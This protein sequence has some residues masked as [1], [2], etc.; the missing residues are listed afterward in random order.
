MKTHLPSFKKPS[1]TWF[2][3][4][5]C[6]AASL[7][8]GCAQALSPVYE[9]A[10]YS[11]AYPVP[12]PEPTPH[13]V[14]PTPHPAQLVASPGTQTLRSVGQMVQLSVKDRASGASL[15][16]YLFRGEYWVAGVPGQAYALTLSSGFKRRVL[17]TTSVDGVN[18]VS[19][20]TAGTLQRGY[21]LSPYA[22]YDIA[23]WRKSEHE[24]AAFNFAAPQ[25]SYAAQT[26]RPANV[27]VIGVA[28]F[29]EQFVPPAPP[30]S[31]PIA[32]PVPLPV[33]LPYP[34][35][36]RDKKTSTVQDAAKDT[37]KDT[38]QNTTMQDVAKSTAKNK[39]A[40]AAEA[41]ATPSA[42]PL[43][44]TARLPAGD[45]RA[46]A[47]RH[48]APSAAVMPGLGTQ[49]GQRESSY[50]PTVAFQR[51]S[52]TPAELISLRYDTV[53]H[54]VARG[55]LRWLGAYQP[56]MHAPAPF[57]QSGF[58]PDPPHLR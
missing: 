16:V 56:T 43:L 46:P 23:G 12:Q 57:P 48:A 52:Q 39:S 51:E 13:V 9:P 15:P 27:G 2:F 29:P 11:A 45:V 6:A 32:A 34:L 21:V 7:Q 3:L 30:V 44:D 37:S 33:P 26:G 17:A 58:V 36:R 49:H 5:L 18:V 50:A 31:A 42:R 22:R 14:L 35:Y 40:E 20:E 47:G 24:I 25:A 1:Q 19:G 41:T 28:V 8:I 54:L 4:S 38:K 10:P 53:D 55:V